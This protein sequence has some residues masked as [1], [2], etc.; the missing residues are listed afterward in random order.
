MEDKKTNGEEKADRFSLALEKYKEQKANILL[1]STRI[2]GLSDW[3]EPVIDHVSLNPDPGEGDVYIQE[4]S[5][6]RDKPSKYAITKQGLMKLSACAGIMWHPSECRRTDDRRDRDYVSFQAV[7]GVRKADGTPIF[8]KAEYDLDFEVIED[9]IEQQYRGKQ[10]GYDKDE[11][12]W[13]TKLGPNGQEDYVQKCIRRDLLQKR[14]HKVKLAE[15]GAMTRV[16][17][18]LLG[19][20]STYSPSELS[21]PFVMA[22]IVIKPDFSDKEVR[23]AMIAASIKSITGVYGGMPEFPK[24]DLPHESAIIE[25][26]EDD[27][28]PTG[29]PDPSGDDNGDGE[30]TQADLDREAFMNLKPPGQVEALKVLAKSKN[31]DLTAIKAPLEKW[32]EVHRVGFYD[33]LVEPEND[34]DIPF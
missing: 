17:R 1:P 27:Y 2:E 14:K 15:S 3:H 25:L 10:K 6:Q 21:K 23:Q 5:N 28:R 11:P 12:G 22:R 31:Y 33:K 8:V 29:D 34:D 30:P 26:N 9:E 16:I 18:S 4:K 13:W 20:K 24:V 7:G 32:G 19:L